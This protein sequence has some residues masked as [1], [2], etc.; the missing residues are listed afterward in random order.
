MDKDDT[1]AL[2]ARVTRQNIGQPY[3]NTSEAQH[4]TTKTKKVRANPL[5]SFFFWKST[6]RI[7]VMADVGEDS[8]IISVSQVQ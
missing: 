1:G 7:V 3:T 5:L 4:R 6:V 8:L 2:E